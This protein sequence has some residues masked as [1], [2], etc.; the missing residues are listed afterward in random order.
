MNPLANLPL[1][2]SAYRAAGAGLKPLAR[3]WLDARAKSGKEDADRLGERYGRASAPRPPGVLVWMHGASV[4][5][6][7]VLLLLREAMAA[8]RGDL[9][10]LITTGTR[11]SARDV[12]AADP[13][14][15]IHQFAPFDPIDGA[16]DAFLA[17]WRPDLG[18]FAESEF[19]PNLLLRAKAAG[20]PLA[21]VNARVSPASLA[22]WGR[23]PQSAARL[24]SCYDLIF[25]ADRASADGLARL[26]RDHVELLSNLKLAAPTLAAP[27]ALL[28]EIKQAI[29]IRPVWLAAS[30]HAG[31]EEIVLAAH[32]K[33]R[34]AR[35]DALLLLAPR[36][37]ERGPAVAAMAGGAPRRAQRDPIAAGPVYVIDTLGELG[38]YFA[39]SPI[40]FMGGSLRAHLKGHNPIEPARLGAAVLTGPHVESFADLYA[41]LFAAGGAREAGD[42]AA[43]A[44]ALDHLWT[45]ETE[46]KRLAAAAAAALAEGRGA[47]IRTRDALLALLDAHLKARDAAA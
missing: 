26:S 14:R 44:A 42:P 33:A 38:A 28:A 13:P 39:A 15:T 3:V 23:F 25:A 32:A 36:H 1:G 16:V 35:G 21:L 43:I 20:A 12:R 40:A 9:S 31:E 22:Q 30:T 11:A 46:R 5:E 29:G 4:G 19:W 7:R 47:L 37:P 2:I 18:I 6:A 27:P 17:H 45:D 10:F 34:E 41:G 8:A 24:L